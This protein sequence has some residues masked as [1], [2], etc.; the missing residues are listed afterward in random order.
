MRF[1]QE[2]SQHGTAHHSNFLSIVQSI[3]QCS[4]IPRLFQP[5]VFDH[6]QYAKTEGEGL[7]EGVMCTTSGSV[8]IDMRGAVPTKNLEVLLNVK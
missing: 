8:R 2:N 7:G 6:L 1:S 4:L 3:V 5:P